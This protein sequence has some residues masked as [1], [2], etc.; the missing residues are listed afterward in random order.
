M[1][2]K[3]KRNNKTMIM[4]LMVA[5]VFVLS[6]AYAAFSTS[7]K[8]NGSASISSTWN[9]GWDTANI[10]CTPT[11][12]DSVKKTTCSVG[13]KTATDVVA[14]ISWASPG[15][16]VVLTVPVKNTGSLAATH[17]MQAYY[18][19]T[20]NVSTACTNV[21]ALVSY[22]GM[23]GNSIEVGPTGKTIGPVSLAASTGTATYT[24]RFVYNSS[25]SSGAGSCTFRASGA[26]TQAV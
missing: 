26:A 22:T 11:S 15:D 14:T 1:T 9:V 23:T 6:V 18:Y 4:V 16:E 17:T 20:S 7:L 2:D 12:N 3:F 10:T 8:I 5:A 19:L 21:S 13:T 25:A 24:I